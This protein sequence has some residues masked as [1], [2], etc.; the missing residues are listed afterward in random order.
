MEFETDLLALSREPRGK[1]NAHCYSG[2]SVIVYAVGFHIWAATES[3]SFIISNACKTRSPI[4]VKVSLH[5]IQVLD[6]TGLWLA[7]NEGMDPC[8]SPYGIH[9]GSF[10]FHFHSF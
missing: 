9:Y 3:S 10:H 4:T 8:N 7:R 5:D 6:V 2:F 1:G